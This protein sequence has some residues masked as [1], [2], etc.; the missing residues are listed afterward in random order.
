MNIA[1]LDKDFLKE[2]LTEQ[3][4]IEQYATIKLLDFNTEEEID[5]LNGIITS[6]TINID[7]KSAVR[8]SCNLSMSVEENSSFTKEDWTFLSKISISIGIKNNINNKYD[9]IIW[10]PQGIFLITSFN[11]SYST[12]SLSISL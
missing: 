9:D 3:N 4:L 2:L 10:F 6:G 11:S 12:N 1:L 7:G 8:R 5:S